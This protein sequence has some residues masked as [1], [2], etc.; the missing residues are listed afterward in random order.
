M[1]YGFLREKTFR[2]GIPLAEIRWPQIV[3]AE[4]L[5]L[6]SGARHGLGEPR[7]FFSNKRKPV[8]VN[9]DYV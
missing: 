5:N 9:K 2:N 1:E 3:W 6:T 8:D 7:R 4:R